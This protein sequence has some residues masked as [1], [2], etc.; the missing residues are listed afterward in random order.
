MK[1]QKQRSNQRGRATGGL[2][3]VGGVL[4]GCDA[5]VPAPE[6]ASVIPSTPGEDR[7]VHPVLP[8]QRRD[9]LAD[10]VAG[11][12]VGQVTAHAL[13]GLDADLAL[14]RWR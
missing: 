10:D 13:P 14:V 3:P 6:S 5:E 4:T 9:L 7:V 1:P 8:H 11:L 12:E 2:L